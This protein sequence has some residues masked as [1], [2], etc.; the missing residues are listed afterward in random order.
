MTIDTALLN[1]L[2]RLGGITLEYEK[3][4]TTK[5][6]LSEIVNFVENIN[7][8]DLNDIPAS[9]NPLDSKLP[10]RQ[11]IAESKLEIA[12]SVLKHAPNAE[13]DFFIVPKI[14]E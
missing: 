6:N 11:D 4:E 12:K 10:M 2:T 5:N 9:F 7:T 3:L 13:D 14:I 1:K 8:L